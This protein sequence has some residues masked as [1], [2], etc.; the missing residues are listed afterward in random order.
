MKKKIFLLLVF[1]ICNT[2]VFCKSYGWGEIKYAQTTTN[3]RENR[4]TNSRVVRQLQPREE[5]KV[6]FLRNN[7]YAI[8]EVEES[9]R[10]EGRAFGYVYAPLLKQNPPLNFR[11]TYWGMSIA[12]V[13]KSENSKFE[14]VDTLDKEGFAYLGGSVR[15]SGIECGFN[16]T[17][18][19]N[20]LAR[21][22]YTDTETYRDPNEYIDDYYK[23]KKYLISKYGE[24]IPPRRSE[25]VWKNERYRDNRKYWGRAIM[26]GHLIFGV[27]WENKNT[28]MWL[29]LAGGN[30]YISLVNLYVSK[31]LEH[32]LEKENRPMY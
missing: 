28:E 23:L 16:Y 24:P 10:E 30:R 2:F 4:N 27:K 26:E 21:G 3:V 6:D 14:Y 5:V 20:K 19:N 8:F 25:M 11:N 29:I 13:K 31:E 17:F 9:K 7:W 12:E 32:L 1:F 15:V 22:R 18:A